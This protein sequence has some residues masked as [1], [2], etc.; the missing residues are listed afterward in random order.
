MWD[1][2]ISCVIEITY[3]DQFDRIIVSSILDFV[4]ARSACG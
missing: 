2:Q 3:L 1:A 4:M